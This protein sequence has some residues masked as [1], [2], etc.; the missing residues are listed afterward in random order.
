MFFKD[1]F[2]MV[3]STIIA[4]FMGACMSIAAMFVDALDKTIWVFLNNWGVITWM[5][6]VILILVPAPKWGGKM[7]G[8]LKCKPDTLA[9]TLVS[10]IIPA[11]IIN[12]CLTALM[13]AINIFGSAVIPAEAKA[14]IWC[15]AFLHDWPIMLVVSY[16]ASVIAGIIGAAIAK[17]AIAGANPVQQ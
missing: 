8:A 17:K 2:G 10:S 4:L 9:F 1:H 16:V 11:V 6:L 12:T 3:V 14:G 5:V 13:A 15:S 7:A